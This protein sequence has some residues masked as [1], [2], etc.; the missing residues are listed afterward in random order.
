MAKNSLTSIRRRFALL[1][2]VSLLILIVTGCASSLQEM[3]ARQSVER[4]NDA[5]VQAKANPKVQANA[6]DPLAEAGGLLQEAKQTTSLS[7]ME[8][9]GYLS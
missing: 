6:P 2:P 9:L 7:E 1:I 8:R 4:A 5:Y 3:R